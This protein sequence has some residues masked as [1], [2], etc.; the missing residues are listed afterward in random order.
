MAE[1]DVGPDEYDLRSIDPFQKIYWSSNSRL[2]LDNR[3]RK[4]SGGNEGV[5]P[6]DIRRPRIHADS[7]SIDVH[8]VAI[9]LRKE[10]RAA[11]ISPPNT[12][13]QNNW[14]T[15]IPK[16]STGDAPSRRERPEGA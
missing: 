1:D 5:V 6:G 2:E 7:T 15:E 11:R 14:T 16:S 12:I 8:D 4:A 3:A 10:T 9:G 13:S